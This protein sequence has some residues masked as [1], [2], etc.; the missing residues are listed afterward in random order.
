[1]MGDR[2]DKTTKPNLKI[3]ACA[4][5]KAGVELVD[6][7]TQ[8][9]YPIE[10]IATCKSDSREWAK[11]IADTATGRDFHV[12]HNISANDKEFVEAIRQREIDLV[13][14]LW[15][16]EIIGKEAIKAA[17]I[18]WLNNH[19]SLL[20]YDQGKH[21]YVWSIINGNPYGVTI[22]FINENVD[23]GPIIFQKEIAVDITDT[24]ESL[25]EKSFCEQIN[26]F[27]ENYSNILSFN[28]SQKEQDQNKRTY[29]HS[30]DIEKVRRID[31]DREYKARDLID[32]IRAQ[33]FTA[34]QC[35][36]ILHQG[37]KYHLKLRIE[38]AGNDEDY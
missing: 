29:H 27:K 20:P 13:L 8:Q 5:N 26:I 6:F 14:L 19:P 7:I 3:A 18:G 10:F 1:M 34:G 21:G 16:P 17:K 28:F 35:S 22:H 2:T 38:K 9:P 24:G 31:L 11:K 12:Y 4:A 32:L 37:E 15:W 23:S 36:Y 33:T 25:Y 30:K